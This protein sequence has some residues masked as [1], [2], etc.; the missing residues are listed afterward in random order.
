[1][2]ARGQEGLTEAGNEP[3]E[4]CSDH[5]PGYPRATLPQ[6][7]PPSLSTSQLTQAMRASRA[8]L[9]LDPATLATMGLNPA[10]TGDEMSDEESEPDTEKRRLN[11]LSGL[12]QGIMREYLDT[13]FSDEGQHH[14]MTFEGTPI[15]LGPGKTKGTGLAF[16]TKFIPASESATPEELFSKTKQWRIAKR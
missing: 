11:I 10:T 5:V 15:Y 2:M 12:R 16:A 14:Q 13:D 9:G 3:N 7:M 8:P 4:R 1:M 6:R